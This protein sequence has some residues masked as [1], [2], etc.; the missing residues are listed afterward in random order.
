ML[1]HTASNTDPDAIDGLGTQITTTSPGEEV[2]E[3]VW[4][5]FQII[6]SGPS[7]FQDI[8]KVADAFAP[9][10]LNTFTGTTID[11]ELGLY[12]ADGNLVLNNDDAGGVLQSQLDFL[13]SRHISHSGPGR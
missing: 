4:F 7:S 6:D 11:T 13:D 2:S 1:N 10:E 3:T 5:E 9:F 8:G 12:D